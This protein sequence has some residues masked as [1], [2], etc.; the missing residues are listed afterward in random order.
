MLP[1]AITTMT[2]HGGGP[3]H[4]LPFHFLSTAVQNPVTGNTQEI[5]IAT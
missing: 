1:G 5:N 2:V 4:R 3:I